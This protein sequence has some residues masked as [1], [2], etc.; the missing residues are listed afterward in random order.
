MKKIIIVIILILVFIQNAQ[1]I[2]EIVLEKEKSYFDYLSDVYYG[3]V[4][5]VENVSPILRVF[6]KDGYIFENSVI[7]S[8]KLSFLYGSTLTYNQIDNGHKSL[9]HDFGIAEPSIKMNFNDN[10]SQFGFSY[11]FLR[12]FEG[13]DNGFTHRIVSL[14]I[15]QNINE[16]QSIVFGQGTRLPYLYNGSLSTYNQ[17]FA[18]KSQI[19]RTFGN[20]RSM[21]IRNIASYKYLDYDIG[22]YDSTRY[23]KDFGQGIDFSGNI[24]IKPFASIEDTLGTLSVGTGYNIGDYYNSYSLYSFFTKYQYKNF[25]F[26]AEYANADGYNGIY[27]SNSKADGYYFT[28]GYD[29]NPKIQLLGRY[30]YI[31]PDKSIHGTDTREY[32]IGL[33]YK[34]FENMKL[35]LNYV[36]SNKENS[37][38]S[39]M[40]IFA[41][42]FII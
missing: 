8:I 37:P 32:T 1:A 31:N 27:Y 12:D 21:G 26:N 10:K 41:T 36:R 28:L 13:Y 25:H 17:D 34:P 4:E 20:V 42:R 3:K 16:N 7:N 14:Y 38:D 30:D 2:E 29:F 9:V 33:T 23:M 15:S 11:N 22:L 5:N 35:I 39:N 19:G 6:S 18:L 40:I 24:V